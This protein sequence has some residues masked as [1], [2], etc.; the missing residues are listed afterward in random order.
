MRTGSGKELSHWSKLRWILMVLAV[1][2]LQFLL[3]MLFSSSE[4]APPVQ[5]ASGPRFHFMAAAP[6]SPERPSHLA[7][8]DPTL[9]ALPHPEGFS[10]PLWRQAPA[11]EYQLTNSIF[12]PRWLEP[13]PQRFG[14][15]FSRFVEET[16]AADFF[17][18]HPAP[19]PQGALALP[20]MPVRT[21]SHLRVAGEISN[22]PLLN[23]PDLPVIPHNQIL[24]NTVVLVT[25]TP[26][27]ESLAVL[28]SG[29]GSKEADQEALRT[30][31]SIRFAPLEKSAPIMTGQL[32]FEWSIPPNRQANPPGNNR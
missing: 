21:D 5:P 11:M 7:V 3:L 2:I 1:F 14:E 29:S 31:R 25:V 13:A 12:P 4:L 19:A 28:L 9:F 23:S 24:A 26:E 27:G 18:T 22:R 10:E 17:S 8:S 6:H 20:S 32:I 15:T 30:A 16:M